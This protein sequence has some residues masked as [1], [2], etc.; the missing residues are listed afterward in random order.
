MI[1][2]VSGIVCVSET[3][4][5]EENLMKSSKPL[6]PQTDATSLRSF[7]LDA[8]GIRRVLGSLEADIMETIWHLTEG[9]ATWTT[10]NAVCEQLGSQVNYKTIQTVMNRLVEKHLLVR[11]QL[12]RA[13]EYQ[14]GISRMALEA[15]VTRTITESLMRD[16]GSSAIVHFVNAVQDIGPE[17]LATLERLAKTA[18]EMSSKASEDDG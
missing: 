7:R 2:E 8:T 3:Q 10:I 12:H 4:Y 1:S 14:P 15:Q 11:R 5:A 18:G 9:S 16:F 13:H 17:H 6:S